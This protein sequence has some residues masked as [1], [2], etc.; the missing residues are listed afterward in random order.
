MKKGCAWKGR[1]C[2]A[3]V[4]FFLISF[5][6]CP[7]PIQAVGS[8]DLQIEQGTSYHDCNGIFQLQVVALAREQPIDAVEIHLDFDPTYLQLVDSSGTPT[9]RV[10]SMLPSPWQ[11]FHNQA[12]NA[13]GSIDFL[14][15]NNDSTSSGTLTIF[16]FYL[17]GSAPT[18]S[19]TLSFCSAIP[20]RTSIIYSGGLGGSPVYLDGVYSSA[21]MRL[22]GPTVSVNLAP[23]TSTV[24]VGS[25]HT[26]TATVLDALGLA[27]GKPVAFTVTGSHPSSTSTLADANGQAVFTYTSTSIGPDVVVATA[28]STNS[29]PASVHWVAGPPSTVLLS[30]EAAIRTVGETHH[31][32]AVVRDTYGNGVGG[33]SVQF[34]VSGAHVQTSTLLTDSDGLVTFTYM[35]TSTGSDTIQASLGAIE[36]NLLSCQWGNSALDHILIA[37][38]TATIVA[39]TTQAYTSTAYD[40]YGNSWDITALTAFSISPNGSFS[41]NVASVSLAGPHAI[42]GSYASKTATASLQVTPGAPHH[43]TFSTLTAQTAGASFPATITAYDSFNNVKTDFTGP[44]TLSG[45]ANSVNPTSIPFTNGVANPTL[46]ITKAMTGV[47]T[48]TSASISNDSNSFTVNPATLDH[49][50]FAAISN[51]T[52]GVPFPLSLTAYDLYNNVKTDYSGPATLSGFDGA[53]APTSIPFSS[54]IATPN[55]TITKAMTGKLTLSGSASNDSNTF[56]V[57]H[58]ASVD[59]LSLSPATATIV[60]GTT[61]AY[62]STAYDA[63]G[64]SWD[65]TALTAFSISPNGFFTGN[66][67]SVSLAGPHTI[68]G[69]YGGKSATASLQVTSGAPHHFTFSTLPSPQ[70]A[71]AS[72]PATITAY[73][74][75]NNVKTDFTGPATLSGFANSVNPTSIPFTNGVANPTLTITKAMSAFLTITS[76]SILNNSN[77]FT[78]NHGAAVSIVLTPDPV[79]ITADD[80]IPTWVVTAVDA[81]SNTWEVTGSS[82][83]TVPADALAKKVGVYIVTAVFGAL[84]DT[85]ALTITHGNAVS[86]AITPDPV[87]ITADDPI[88]TWVVTA[89]DAFSNTWEVTGSSTITVPADALAKKVGVYTVNAALGTLTDTATL[90]ITHGAATSITLTPKDQTI[91]A[92]D[93]IPTWA[94]TAADAAGNTWDITAL[95]TV[96][97]PPNALAKKV[98]VY[99]VNAV[100]LLLTDTATLTVNYGAAIAISL[101][102]DPVTITADDPIPTWVV[103]A[104]DAFSNTWEVTGYSIIT[105]PAN[106]LAKKVGVYTVNA[107]L[108][109]LTDTAA[110]TLIHGAAI[111]IFLTPDPVTI[112][113]DDPIP[114]WAV[115]AI[116]AAGN[117]WVVTGYSIITIPANA[118]AKKV[119]VYTVTAAYLALTDTAQLTIVPGKVASIVLTPA[120][121]TNVVGTTHTLSALVKDAAQNVIPGVVV[122]FNIV[123]A[124]PA[125]P[126]FGT[127]TTNTSGVTTFSYTQALVGTDQIVAFGGDPS[128][129][130]NSASK[131]WIHG[132]AASIS[133]TPDP[134][135]IT[136]DDP[137]PTW[138]VTAADAFS[139]TWE[140]T[141]SSTITVPAD[142]LAKLVGVYT[143]TANYL[144]LTDTDTLTIVHGVATSIALTP[145]ISTISAG[146]SQSYQSNAV[147][148]SGNA[149]DVTLSSTFHIDPAAGGSWTGSLY[150]SQLAGDWS[151]TSQYQTFTSTSALLVIPGSPQTLTVSSSTPSCLLGSPFEVRAVLF[152]ALGNAIANQLVLFTV[153]GA[154][155]LTG[156]AT[157]DI[158]GRAAWTYTCTTAGTDTIT[159]S[160]GAASGS[161]TCVWQGFSLT[162]ETTLQG[163][164]GRAA[165]YTVLFYQP[166][167][168]VLLFSRNMTTATGLSSFTLEDLLP[169]LFTIRLK[170]QLC[171]SMEKPSVS[172]NQ[173]SLFSCGEQRTGDANNDDVVNIMDFA[174]LKAS[175]GK[176]MGQPSFDSRAD[177]NGDGTVNPTD[178]ALMK[179]NFGRWGPL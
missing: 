142:A 168:L 72:F 93:P 20:R 83:I 35:A 107:T 137:L 161:T 101:T 92:D 78:V 17:K 94:V 167:T 28:D 104:V 179:S 48:I 126:I 177:F 71:G 105:I 70:T 163:T 81:F 49:F 176:S 162:I 38:A 64:N 154:H 34:T 60:A 141:G 87:T 57:T 29:S 33:Q 108:G 152:D 124:S 119:G 80:P 170:E 155:P 147:D 62:T 77:T 52:A 103:T 91:T 157:T 58:S 121:A 19:T 67:A 110:L 127:G 111:A 45:F 128:V 50:T 42:T 132:P 30:Q 12:S 174:V 158:T 68:T 51:Q 133:L 166:E 164:A 40:A 22:V 47:L 109:V 65:V 63:Y 46:T 27:P 153:S 106:A 31:V 149:W 14:A 10:E 41:G 131:V 144:L 66:I 76:A 6:Y 148:S 39:G 84:T 86:I 5:L 139:N 96:T 74:S 136:A 169:G 98:G 102:P 11:S 4:G 171:L 89:V 26:Q 145:Q 82:T 23:T 24:V 175:F 100:Y 178:F 140:V 7:V 134:V 151:V 79:T 13:S 75:F 173:D 123:P 32:D 53:V 90:T 73:D 88:P 36:S 130:S 18:L 122:T 160:A 15:G 113:A 85:A 117:T 2:T 138:A 69:S 112:T 43:F 61:Q 99:A 97:V 143:V 172:I 44:A 3:L 21:G 156:T 129:I 115:T 59:H 150:T 37:P 95:S 116:D 16:S 8:V 1:I 146:A 54:G 55:V 118:L 125:L 25:M 135:T 9:N 114:T 120:T 165:E 56:T 159:A